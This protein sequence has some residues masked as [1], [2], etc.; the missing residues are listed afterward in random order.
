MAYRGDTCG[1]CCALSSVVVVVVEDVIIFVIQLLGFPAVD[2]IEISLYNLLIFMILWS[3]IVATF[4]DPGFLPRGHSHLNPSRLPANVIH[5]YKEEMHLSG[6]QLE[7]G[8]LARLYPPESV[9]HP[10]STRPLSA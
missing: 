5:F 10:N 2:Y 8:A 6:D 1:C 4:A 3:H 7:M 9:L